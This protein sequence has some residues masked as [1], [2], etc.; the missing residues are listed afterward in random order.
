MT[1]WSRVT[2]ETSG[3]IS[4]TCQWHDFEEVVVTKTARLGTWIGSGSWTQGGVKNQPRVW[5]SLSL[6]LLRGPG[7][8]SSG[9]GGHWHHE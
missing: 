6:M 2:W 9:S 5:C 3:R 7:G 8:D 1:A 4:R